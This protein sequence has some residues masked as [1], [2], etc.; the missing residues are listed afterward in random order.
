MSSNFNEGSETRPAPPEYVKAILAQIKPEYF[1]I[2]ASEKGNWTPMQAIRG[3]EG[4]EKDRSR[5]FDILELTLPNQVV[6]DYYH[7]VLN[8]G[9]EYAYAVAINPLIEAVVDIEND[10]LQEDFVI[11]NIGG[12]DKLKQLFPGE[13]DAEIAFGFVKACRILFTNAIFNATFNKL[14]TDQDK[15]VGLLIYGLQTSFDKIW[16]G[17]NEANKYKVFDKK[18]KYHLCSQMVDDIEKLSG[19]IPLY[20]LEDISFASASSLKIDDDFLNKPYVLPLFRYLDLIN[21]IEESKR[22]LI[23]KPL[24]EDKDLRNLLNQAET[25]LKLA[26][27]GLEE[28]DSVKYRQELIDLKQTEHLKL[29]EQQQINLIVTAITTLFVVGVIATL[30]FATFGGGAAL[31][32]LIPGIVSLC[33]AAC[34]GTAPSAYFA[35]KYRKAK[36]VAQPKREADH[37]N[38]GKNTTTNF[39]PSK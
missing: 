6:E 2:S 18:N 36:A 34:M 4:G 30:T 29:V 15:P 8:Y 25:V 12:K 22:K 20:N 24:S 13:K 27:T 9:Y 35:D 31:I 33:I 5:M 21:F 19:N 37:D 38:V 1:D 7:N 11:H 39:S 23:N 10:K 28:N 3:I 16:E 26:E 17:G 32:P 14:D